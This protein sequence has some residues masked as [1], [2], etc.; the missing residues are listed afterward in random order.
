MLPKRR[1]FDVCILNFTSCTLLIFVYRSHSVT[2]AN[3][4]LGRIQPDYFPKIFGPTE[5]MPLDTEIATKKFK[6][7]TNLINKDTGGNKTPEEVASGY[8]ILLCFSVIC[9]Y[10]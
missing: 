7:L 3:L 2:D 4:F 5:N 8:V 6:E 1:S 9:T 10:Y